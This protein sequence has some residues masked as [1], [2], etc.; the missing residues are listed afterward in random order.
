M[1]LESE[2]DEKNELDEEK[3]PTP[4]LVSHEGRVQKIVQS[5][6]THHFW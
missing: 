6:R 5:Y 3:A 4:V 2:K 1:S